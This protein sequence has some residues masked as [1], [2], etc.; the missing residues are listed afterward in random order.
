MKDGTKEQKL[1]TVRARMRVPSHM[2]Q[3]VAWLRPFFLSWSFE[4]WVPLPSSS[5]PKKGKAR[6]ITEGTFLGQTLSSPASG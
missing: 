3:S 4:G 2:H 1:V 5:S 6:P